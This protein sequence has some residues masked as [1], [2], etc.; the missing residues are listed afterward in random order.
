MIPVAGRS[1]TF[2]AGQDRGVFLFDWD[3]VSERP[4]RLETLAE[5]QPEEELADLCLNDGKVDRHGRLWS[6]ECW[7]GGRGGGTTGVRADT[8]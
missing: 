8:R 1:G 5:L 2:V 7:W 4:R 3:G 6:G